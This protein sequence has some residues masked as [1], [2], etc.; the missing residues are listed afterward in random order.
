MISTIYQIAMPV[1]EGTL[2]ISLQILVHQELNQAKQ[3][4][5]SQLTPYKCRKLTPEGQSAHLSLMV[6]QDA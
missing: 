5:P 1:M 6:S 4:P 2:N 3:I